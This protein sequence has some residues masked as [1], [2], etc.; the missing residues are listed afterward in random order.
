MGR[1]RWWQMALHTSAPP[2]LPPFAVANSSRS[3][4]FPPSLPWPL[5]T[6]SLARLTLRKSWYWQEK[7]L[8]AH[9]ESTG[10]QK[11]RGKRVQACVSRQASR[12]VHLSLRS[13]SAGSGE[14]MRVPAVFDWDRNRGPLTGNRA[15]APVSHLAQLPDVCHVRSSSRRVFGS[16]FIF[17]FR[18]YFV[19]AGEVTTC[20]GRLGEVPRLPACDADEKKLSAYQRRLLKCH[21]QR[22]GELNSL[23]LCRPVDKA[24]FDFSL[25]T[26]ESTS[27]LRRKKAALKVLKFLI[28]VWNGRKAWPA[29][30]RAGPPFSSEARHK[31]IAGGKVT[32]KGTSA[33]AERKPAMWL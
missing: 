16:P 15:Q 13:K 25:A 9:I 32:P 10:E 7:M 8:S 11:S 2:R 5:T 22:L 33:R 17:L 19:F 31:Q 30:T 12:C 27:L 24:R 14:L 20:Q 21:F 18:G 3:N 26:Q 28:R 23:T 29:L 1:I 4:P 6:E